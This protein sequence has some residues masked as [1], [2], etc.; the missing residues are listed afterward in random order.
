V[1][2][3][4][5][6]LLVLGCPLLIII[7]PLI[8]LCSSVTAPRGVPDRVAHYYTLSP[9]SVGT[10]LELGSQGSP[11]VDGNP[12]GETKVIDTR[13]VFCLLLLLRTFIANLINWRET[14]PETLVITRNPQWDLR[15]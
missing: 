2:L 3:G 4:Q 9:M 14:L 11:L 1:T 5:V 13:G 12:H 10:W 15:N 6:Y 8:A 7:T